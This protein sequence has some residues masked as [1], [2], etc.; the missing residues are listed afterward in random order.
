MYLLNQYIELNDIA[1]VF[2]K[3]KKKS[4]KDGN[5]KQVSTYK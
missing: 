1:N 2:Q 4:L 5:D 3:K